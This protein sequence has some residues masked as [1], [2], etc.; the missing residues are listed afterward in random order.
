MATCGIDASCTLWTIGRSSSTALPRLMPLCGEYFQT[1]GGGTDT[2]EWHS[3]AALVQSQASYR[4]RKASSRSF[5]SHTGEQA[6]FRGCSTSLPGLGT[7]NPQLVLCRSFI[8]PARPYVSEV[9]KTSFRSDAI[10]VSRNAVKTVL[11]PQLSA[12]NTRLLLPV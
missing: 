8:S 1:A 9:V 12:S 6:C 11:L 2:M 3:V 4:Q 5:I 10:L 7:S